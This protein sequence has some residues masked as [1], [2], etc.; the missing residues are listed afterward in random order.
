MKFILI[1]KGM[2]GII[3]SR[4][5][6]P[7]EEGVLKKFSDHCHKSLSTI[8]FNIEP[9]YRQLIKWET[10]SIKGMRQSYNIF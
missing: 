6:L 9:E 10:C 4:V 8:F 3:K 7:T 5:K 2:W 1:D